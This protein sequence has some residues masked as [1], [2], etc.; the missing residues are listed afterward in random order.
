VLPALLLLADALGL[1][2]DA[3]GRHLGRWLLRYA[4]FAVVLAAYLAIRAALFGGSELRIALLDDPIGPLR[5]LGFALQSSFAPRLDLAYE[6]EL[7]VWHSAP[8]LAFALAVMLVLAGAVWREGAALRRRA[9]FWAAWLLLSLLPTANVLHQEAPFD[10]RYV[11][12]AW[13]ALPSVAALIASAHWSA[14]RVRGAATALGLVAVAACAWASA[15]RGASFRDDETFAVQWLRTNPVSPEAHHALGLL[16][17]Q[18]GRPADAIAPLRE[19]MRLA[20]E[21]A[22]VRHN[23]GSALLATGKTEGARI[24]LETALRLAPDHPE[25]HNNLGLLLAAEG[26]LDEA[27]AHYRA[28]LHAAPSFVEAMNNLATVLARQ[29]DPASA[30]SELMRALGLAPGYADAHRN[31]AVILAQ[32]GREAEAAAHYREAERASASASR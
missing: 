20:P 4:P 17:L 26:R 29:G 9:A 6:P 10:E 13:L 28:A 14:P 3:P 19:A 1:A 30:E 11:F 8:R 7:A 32:Q 21:S 22:E 18:T 5:S 31:L 16:R 24:E 12:L 2:P 27:A 23:L 25:A 15:G